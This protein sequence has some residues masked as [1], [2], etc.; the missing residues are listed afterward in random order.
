MTWVHDSRAME[1]MS[2]FNSRF[3]SY[4]RHTGGCTVLTANGGRLHV[5]GIGA[6]YVDELGVVQH[7]LHVPALRAILMSPQHLV[8][9]VLY[10]FHLQPGEMFV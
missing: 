7:V 2:Q 8:D 10:S 5:V 6:V 1:H 3:V 9:L 4:Q